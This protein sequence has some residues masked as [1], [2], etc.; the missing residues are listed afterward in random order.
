MYIYLFI[1]IKDNGLGILEDNLNHIL[2][3][4]ENEDCDSSHIGI[5]NVYKRIKLFYDEN[6]GIDVFSDE[7][8]TI[9]TLKLNAIIKGD[10]NF[11]KST[12]NR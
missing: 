7:N 4:F 12:Y 11:D 1:S 3:E 10:L 2:K 8:N 6:C 5:N 9:F